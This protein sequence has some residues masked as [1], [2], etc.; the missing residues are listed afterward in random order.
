M[1]VKHVVVAGMRLRAL[2]YEPCHGYHGGWSDVAR[3]RSF[4]RDLTR[5][6]LHRDAAGFSAL[7]DAAELDCA[8][9]DETSAEESSRL[10]SL[11][12]KRTKDA[13]ALLARSS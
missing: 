11:S 9:L 2:G 13:W 6:G 3:L 12:L 5:R 7:A 10:L 4:Q 8:V 1:S